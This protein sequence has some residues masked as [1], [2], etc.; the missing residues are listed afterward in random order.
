MYV[1]GD[2]RRSA[3]R[4]GCYGFR[5][6]HPSKLVMS[7]LI[8]DPWCDRRIALAT[9]LSLL[10]GF[11]ILPSAV[12]Q[13]LPDMR[14]ALIGSGKDALINMIDTQK[15]SK[16]GQGDAALMFFATLNQRGHPDF[17]SAYR[18]TPGGEKLKNE[19]VRCMYKAH[20]VP[21]VYNHA[22]VPAKIYG[23]IIFRVVDGKPH[24]RIFLNQEMSELKRESDFIGPQAIALPGHVYERIQ[25]PRGPWASE[26]KPGIVEVSLSV[27]ASGEL[28]DV[29]VLKEMPPGHN[30]GALMIK[31]IRQS[32]YLPAFRNGKPVDS[33]THFHMTLSPGRR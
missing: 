29:Q 12:A 14:P 3:I 16:E 32:T 27:D 9:A 24:L 25:Y 13:D 2:A 8:I 7:L 30:F 10:A 28:K 31:A 21:A 20:F 18:V 4:I 11:V 19:V 23:T 17:F 33:T 22:N 26:D 5:A 6:I 15:L 1:Y